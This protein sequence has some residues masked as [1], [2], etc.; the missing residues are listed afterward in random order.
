[1]WNYPYTVNLAVMKRIQ[2]D[3]FF[4]LPKEKRPPE[5]IWDD[6]AR[7]EEWFD[8]VFDRKKETE[9]VFTIPEHEIES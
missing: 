5:S 6:P 3:S 8:R 9:F 7:L 2:I 1:M 4:E